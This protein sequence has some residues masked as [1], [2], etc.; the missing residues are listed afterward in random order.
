MRLFKAFRSFFGF[1]VSLTSFGGFLFRLFQFFCCFV[2]L[3]VG[4]DKLLLFRFGAVKLHRRVGAFDNLGAFHLNTAAGFQVV[5]Q[6][7]HILRILTCLIGRVRFRLADFP[8]FGISNPV[9]HMGYIMTAALL[10]LFFIKVLRVFGPYLVADLLFPF[11]TL[12]KFLLRLLQLLLF[13]LFDGFPFC[14]AFLKRSFFVFLRR[15]QGFCLHRRTSHLWGTT[16]F[17]RAA[18]RA[19]GHLSLPLSST[20]TGWSQTKTLRVRG[21]SLFCC[22]SSPPMGFP[23]A[24]TALSLPQ[25]RIASIFSG[26]VWDSGT[27]LLKASMILASVIWK[28]SLAISR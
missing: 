12:V 19:A 7:L 15:F 13:G 23:E 6:P 28:P 5:G 11:G 4:L 16:F 9:L 18:E 20:G 8:L 2:R 1:L 3:P 10:I 27:T 17:F 14:S 21:L 26:L 22:N 25:S 24:G